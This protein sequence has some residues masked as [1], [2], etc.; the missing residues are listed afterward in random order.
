QVKEIFGIVDQLDSEIDFLAWE[1]RPVLLDDL[2][3]EEALRIYVDRWKQHVGIAAEFHTSGFGENR[4]APEIENNFYRIT[5]EALNNVAKH[6][7]AS[8][9][10][11]LLERRNHHA[12]LIVE[13]DGVGF[14]AEEEVSQIDGKLGLSGIKERASLMNADFEI[15]SSPEKGTTVFVSVPFNPDKL[16]SKEIDR[17]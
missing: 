4:L 13:D 11:V 12:V 3:L 17:T 6:A 7:R 10:A 9:A 14:K 8:R 15:E 1:L 5:Q 16:C 2:G